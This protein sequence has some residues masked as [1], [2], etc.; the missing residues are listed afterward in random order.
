MSLNP[1]LCSQLSR[2]GR[3]LVGSRHGRHEWHCAVGCT[4]DRRYRRGVHRGSPVDAGHGSGG[5]RFSDRRLGAGFRAAVQ[6]TPGVRRLGRARRRRGGRRGVRRHPALGAPGGGRALSGGREARAVREGVHAQRP[7]GGRAG[8]ARPGPG[9]LPDGGDVD[10]LQPGDPAHDGAGAGRCDRRDPLRAGRLRAGGPFG[11]GH[12]LRDRALG[13]GALLD[14]GV[15]PVSFAH[16]LLGEP[17][18]VQADAVLSPRVSICTPRWCW[19]GRRRAPRR[20]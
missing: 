8:E 3:N 17:D 14:L 2:T 13:G 12:R 7:G 5:R 16:L 9:P 18:R 19:A 6:D 1:H 15:Y 20:C 4:G 10:V 11:P